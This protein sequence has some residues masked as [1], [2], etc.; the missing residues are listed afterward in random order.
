MRLGRSLPFIDGGALCSVSRKFDIGV[1]TTV[2]SVNP[3]RV[4]TYEEEVLIRCVTIFPYFVHTHTHAC[5]HGHTH[6]HPHA[7]TCTHMHAH[8]HMH[9]H[10]C[11]H[12]QAHTC[13]HA[14]SHMHTHTCTHM[15]AL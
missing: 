4:Y 14:H 7:H 5:A 2:T 15:H 11:T 6:M 10:A 9:T 1:Y 8:S 13:M 3:L 12:T